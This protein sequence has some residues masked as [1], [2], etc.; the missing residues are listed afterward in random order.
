[1]QNITFESF[2]IAFCLTLFAGLST[3]IGAAL[4]FLS[5]KDNKKMLSIGLGF[6]AGVMIFVS[7][8][9]ILSKSKLAFIANFGE[10]NGEIFA[11][12]CFF[13]G[14][15]F[16]AF[17]DRLIPEDIN[18]HELK[19]HNELKHLHLNSNAS[20]IPNLKRTGIFTA[21]AIGIHNFPEGFATFVASLENITLGISIA[22]AIALHNIPEGMSVSLPIYHA[23]GNKIKAFKYAFLSGFAEPIGAIVG[24]FVL[25]PIL[26]DMT[27]GIVFGV[28]AGI[29]VYISFDELLPSSRI[30]GN[31][32]TSI[33]GLTAGMLLMAVSLIAFKF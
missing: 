24:F 25:L 11:T 28:V 21:I 2:A 6:S 1:M 15:L 26:G 23:T 3:A 5:K 27:L 18:P 30:Y 29:M 4:V 13:L 32:H 9:E 33:F 17:I 12:L 10:V 20:L 7:F 31:A 22:I 16:A 14:I 8:V 19:T